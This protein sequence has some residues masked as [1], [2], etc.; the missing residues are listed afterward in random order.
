M[1]PIFGFLPALASVIGVPFSTAVMG[2]TV[3]ATALG[4]ATSV[5]ALK[6]A[7][8]ADQLV[9]PDNSDALGA[10]DQTLLGTPAR[11]DPES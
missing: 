1:V 9:E 8:S 7:Q 4:A 5:G 10:D 6:L 3:I 2:G 11:V